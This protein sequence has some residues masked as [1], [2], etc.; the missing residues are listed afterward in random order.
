MP[1]QE[2]N[3]VYRIWFYIFLTGFLMGILIMNLGSSF[4]LNEEGIF[5]AVSLNRLKY[6]EVD[7]HVFFQYVLRQRMKLFL[8]LGLVSTTCF[9]VVAAYVCIAWQGLLIGMLITAAVIR[10][11][12]RGILLVL[13]GIFPQQ[14]LLIPAAVMML[15]WC[16]QNCCFLYYPSKCAW[17][18]YRNRK[19]QYLHQAAVLL[20]IGAVVLIG[21][22]LECYV[23]P[24][25]VSDIVKIF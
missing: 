19:K 11:G 15:G 10:F 5:S 17:P 9:G 24:I 6:M 25:L 4:F 13:A 1:G 7:S 2:R 23:N 3:T 22:I 14:L 12:I 16:Y 20:W 18:V 8:F 21:C